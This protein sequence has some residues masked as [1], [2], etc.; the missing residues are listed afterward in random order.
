MKWYEKR[1]HI[2]KLGGGAL[3]NG[4]YMGVWKLTKFP[5]H[6][7]PRLPPRLGSSILTLQ[8]HSLPDLIPLDGLHEKRCRHLWHGC[9]RIY[10]RFFRMFF[11]RISLKH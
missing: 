4:S 1:R 11:R 2:E 7:S 10:P 5:T 3:R 6:R 8:K 9:S